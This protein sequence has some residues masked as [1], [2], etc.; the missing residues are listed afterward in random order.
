MR[1]P[2][3]QAKNVVLL[4]RVRSADEMSVCSCTVLDLLCAVVLEH[5]SLFAFAKGFSA[6]T[7]YPLLDFLGTSIALFACLLHNL[8]IALLGMKSTSLIIM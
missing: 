1:F 6:Y 5:V 2:F 7:R 4:T 3:L 8:H